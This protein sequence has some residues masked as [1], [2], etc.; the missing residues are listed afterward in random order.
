MPNIKD[1][2]YV[3]F[4]VSDLGKQQQF[5]HDFGLHTSIDE[6]VL[7]ARGTDTSPYIY[8]A[9][10]G[11][12]P[13]FASVGFLADSEAQLREIAAIDGVA[14]TENPLVG[15]GLIAQLTDPKRIHGGHCGKHRRCSTS[16]RG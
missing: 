6:G 5:L 16:Y 7:V 9:E 2:R 15:G 10:E 8:L 13:A 12:T 3:K 4:R 11:P 14:V 1:V